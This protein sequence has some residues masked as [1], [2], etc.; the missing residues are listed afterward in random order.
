[1]PE[2]RVTDPSCRSFG[3]R[4]EGTA[5]RAAPLIYRGKRMKFTGYLS[6]S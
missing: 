1:M 5:F 2:V 3:S 6:G 4:Q